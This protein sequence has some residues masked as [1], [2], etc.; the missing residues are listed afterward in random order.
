M[1][2]CICVCISGA[3]GL[4]RAMLE[5]NPTVRLT[6]SQTLQNNW[7]LHAA[8]QSDQEEATDTSNVT[9]NKKDT[10]KSGRRKYGAWGNQPKPDM[11]AEIA[12]VA[13]TEGNRES[14]IIKYRETNM[15]QTDKQTTKRP[16]QV[17]EISKNADLLEVSVL[18][19]KADIHE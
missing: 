15:D 4:I 8:A 10:L 18:V 19:Q 11:S 1:T 16:S 13:Q 3:K 17:R 7:L 6:A 14:S 12:Q 5:L 9:N 2:A